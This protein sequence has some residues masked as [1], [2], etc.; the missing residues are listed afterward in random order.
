[1][2][3]FDFVILGFMAVPMALGFR[4]GLIRSLSTLAAVVVGVFL[5]TRFWRQASDFV[6]AVITDENIAGIAA[7]ILIMV[8][9]ILAAWAA[10]AFVRRVVSMLLLGWVDKLGGVAFGALVGALVVSAII[11]ALESYSLPGLESAM[12]ES[13]LHPAFSLFVTILH[14]FSGEVDIARAITGG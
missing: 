4:T 9:T 12:K 7:F 5:A 2:N 3:W 8:G 6:G 11:W 13:V 10:A 14:K 1:M